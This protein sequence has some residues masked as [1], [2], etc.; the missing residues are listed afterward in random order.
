MT[1]SSLKSDE[2]RTNIR[3]GERTGAG[4][5]FA[6]ARSQTDRLDLKELALHA[7]V[8]MR[9]RAF[10]YRFDIKE[11]SLVK[12][13]LHFVSSRV[14]SSQRDEESARVPST[15]DGIPS[16]SESSDRS[17]SVCASGGLLARQKEG[18]KRGDEERKRKVEHGGRQAACRT[19]SR[20]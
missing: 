3:Q 14:S 11:R 15:F 6:E 5:S 13:Y 20:A 16:L 4:N 8:A 12:Q 1:D 10:Q 7:Y 9:R 17:R 2:C 18:Q 19:L